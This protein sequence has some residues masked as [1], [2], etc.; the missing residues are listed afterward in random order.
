MGAEIG[1][2]TRWSTLG[3]DT[4]NSN[5]S[6]T[7]TNTAGALMPNDIAIN[8]SGTTSPV[9]KECDD[10][11]IG[12]GGTG[13]GEGSVFTPNF[14]W[15]VDGD[16]TVVMNATKIA[17]DTDPNTV[18]VYVEGSVDGTNYVTMVDLGDWDANDSGYT[19]GH[20]IYDFNTYG[21]MPY[22]RLNIDGSAV[23]NT[24]NNDNPIKVVVIPHSAG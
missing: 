13:D 6:P 14:N 15:M 23:A 1:Y 17:M 24:G 9:R 2:S 22:M 3:N 5:A 16:F 21:R 20:F 19:V 10:Y 8:G 18:A 7:A 12:T 4:M 11:I